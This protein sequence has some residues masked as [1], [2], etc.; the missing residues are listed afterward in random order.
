MASFCLVACLVV[1]VPLA[2]LVINSLKLPREFLTVP[3]TILPTQVTFEHYGELFEDEQDLSS[4]QEQFDGHALDDR[5]HHHHA[6][7]WRLMAWRACGFPPRSWPRSRSFSYS[8][9]FI[10]V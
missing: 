5:R 2:Y 9:A 4:L 3:P 6:G 10:R 7:R 1:L 8:S